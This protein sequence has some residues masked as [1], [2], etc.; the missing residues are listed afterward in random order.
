[1]PHNKYHTGIRRDETNENIWIRSADGEEV[2]LDGWL[3]DHPAD[4]YSWKYLYWGLWTNS[5]KNTILDKNDASYHF[6][7]EY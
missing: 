3:P 5:N 4:Y 6:I 7:C 1:M 2:E